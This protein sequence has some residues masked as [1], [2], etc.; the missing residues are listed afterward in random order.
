[1][2][3]LYEL[4]GI[5]RRFGDRDVLHIPALTL[6]AGIVYGL[7]GPNGAGKTTLMRI[8]AFMDAPTD[9][10]IAFMGQ[11]VRPEQAPRYRA[12][13]VWVPQSP[14]MFTG[15]LLYNIEYP[16]RLKGTPVKERRSRA[17]ALLERVGLLRLA[18]APAHRLSGGEAQRASIARALAAGAEVLL[19][20]EPT[21]S[22]DFRSR[23]E[24]ITLIRTLNSERGLSII[25]TTHDAALAAALCRERIILFDGRIVPEYPEFEEEGGQ[26]ALPRPSLLEDGSMPRILLPPDAARGEPEGGTARIAALAEGEGGVVLRLTLPSGQS[27]TVSLPEGQGGAR[28]RGFFL[29][30]QLRFGVLSE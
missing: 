3:V 7:L 25:V 21:A 9:G 5:G 20:D 1:M 29:G 18:K 2:P 12:R 10:T 16:M 6:H 19:F 15:S 23:G 11:P 8:L 30:Q 4:T 22:V 28:A 14:V 24:I 27:A 17:L 26:G 13:V